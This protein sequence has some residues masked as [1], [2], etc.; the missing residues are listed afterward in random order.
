MNTLNVIAPYR[1]QGSWVFDDERFDLT[2]EPFICGADKMIDVLVADIP[3]ADAGFKLIFAATAFPSHQ[4]AVDWIRE[5]NGGNWYYSSD[6]KIEGWLCPQ[7]RNWFD[8]APTRIFAKAELSTE[9][10]I[11]R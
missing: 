11:S 3:N 2:R 5:E 7:M 1:W 6:Y 9:H 10:S 8:K 4:L